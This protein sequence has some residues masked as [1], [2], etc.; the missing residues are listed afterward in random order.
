MIY[1]PRRRF[2]P[3]DNMRTAAHKAAKRRGLQYTLEIKKALRYHYQ[4]LADKGKF[5]S[6]TSKE[7]AKIGIKTNV[8]LIFSSNQALLAAKAG[9]TYVSIFI[10][11]LDDNG[12][13]GMDVVWDTS[14][15]FQNYE[16]KSKIIAASIRH[17][18]HVVE[19]AKAGSHIAT[20]PPTILDKMIQHPLTNDGI[21][22]F[23]DDWTKVTKS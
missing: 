6:P 14:Q 17:P 19:A 20:I 4:L 23:A 2:W 5:E 22:K 11:R 9:A 18:R 21:K 3:S 10:G 12:Q 8:T 16:I 13:D 7:L 1:M 15:I